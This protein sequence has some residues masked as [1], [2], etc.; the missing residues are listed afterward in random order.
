ML[1][2]DGN[3]VASLF[4]E[5]KSP[6]ACGGFL[7]CVVAFNLSIKNQNDKTDSRPFLIHSGGAQALGCNRFVD[8]GQASS[9]CLVQLVP[10]S[11][12]YQY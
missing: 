6:A 7:Y 2:L 1:S 3:N 4:P 12:L 5:G 9:Q 10:E 8:S 11:G